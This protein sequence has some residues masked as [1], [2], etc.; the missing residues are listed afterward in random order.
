MGMSED[1]FYSTT[2]RYFHN[3]LKGWR[4]NMEREENWHKW[5]LHLHRRFYSILYNINIEKLHRK[6]ERNYFPFPWDEI[7]KEVTKEEAMNWARDNDLVEIPV[8]K[9]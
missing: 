5:H 3:R 4:R 1:E 2:P 9:F 7:P 8:D 6:E